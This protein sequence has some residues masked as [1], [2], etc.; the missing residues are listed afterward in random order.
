MEH[1][2]ALGE[3]IQ[4]TEKFNFFS[5]GASGY[6]FLYL[7]SKESFFERSQKFLSSFFGYLALVE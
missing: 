6:N 5:R 4:L 1:T 3:S 7:T 2:Q